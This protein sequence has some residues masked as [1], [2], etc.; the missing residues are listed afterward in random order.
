MATFTIDDYDFGVDPGASEIAISPDRIDITIVGRKDAV[1]S[2]WDDDDHPWS[3]LVYPPKIY[4]TGVPI[5]SDDGGFDRDI[6]E[7][8]LEQYDIAIYVM[9]HCDIL[10]CRVSLRDGVLSIRGQVHEIRTQPLDFHV[11]LN[12]LSA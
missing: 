6:T 9:K 5:T 12:L 4:L 10:P 7:A 11:E 2:L 3:W 8:D 1:E